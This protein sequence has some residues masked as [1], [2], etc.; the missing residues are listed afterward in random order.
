MHLQPRSLADSRSSRR[1]PTGADLST[2]YLAGPGPFT[3]TPLGWRDR[4]KRGFH[5]RTY[6]QAELGEL[7]DALTTQGLDPSSPVLSAAHVVRVTMWRTPG[8]PTVL[9]VTLTERP[10]TAIARVEEQTDR[11]ALEVCGS[12]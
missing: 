11:P 7:R 10:R 4:E 9:P 6:A 12:F 2:I 1:I 8:A 3:A 5:V